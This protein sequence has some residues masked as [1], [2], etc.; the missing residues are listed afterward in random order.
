MDKMKINDII[1]KKNARAPSKEGMTELVKSVKEHGVLMPVLVRDV[2][3]GFELVAGFRRVEA[4]KKAGLKEIPA[5]LVSAKEDDDAIVLQVVENLQRE[6]MSPIEEAEAYQYLVEHGMKQT[7]IAKAVGKSKGYISQRINLLKVD[8]SVRES[9]ERGELPVS[10]VRDLSGMSKEDQKKVVEKAKKAAEDG[11]KVTKSGKKSERS[12][13][14][15][16]VKEAAGKRSG[17]P[18]KKEYNP[19]PE[20]IETAFN[21]HIESFS[22]ELEEAPSASDLELLDMFFVFLVKQKVLIL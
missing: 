3:E 16:A 19:A 22:E 8:D 1:I 20:E 2:P 4:A 13:K 11:T 18:G 9:V 10:S 7:E 14:G 21:F 6:D 17:K 12:A 15:E 5:S